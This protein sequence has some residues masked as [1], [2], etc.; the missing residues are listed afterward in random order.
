MWYD[1]AH[2]GITYI[3]RLM[4]NVATFTVFNALIACGVDNIAMFMEQTQ[5][6]RIADNIFDNVFTSC[7]DITFKE[8]DD[9]FKTY[10][11]LSVAQGQIRLRPGIRK[12]IKAFV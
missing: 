1:E 8:L 7:M 2:T 10:S 3:L 12:N 9:H 11:E 4:A 6:E 5:A